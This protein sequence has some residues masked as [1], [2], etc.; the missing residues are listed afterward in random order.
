M[1]PGEIIF[2]VVVAI[3]ISIPALLLCLA[4][5]ITLRRWL[6]DLPQK[7]ST[8]S[9]KSNEINISDEPPKYKVA[10]MDPP[11]YAPPNTYV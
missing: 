5:S 9:Q 1:Y 11:D 4:R 6:K 3:M 8:S 10:I 2:I 7:L